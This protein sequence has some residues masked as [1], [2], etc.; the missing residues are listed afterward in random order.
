[1]KV[2][3]TGANGMLGRATVDYLSSVGDDVVGLTKDELDIA[4][5]ELVRNAVKTASPDTV[6]NC[7]AWTDVDGCETDREKNY[8]V[9]A[10]GPENLAVACR[11]IGANLITVST[12][13]VF[14]GRKDG[15]YTQRDE[16]NPESEYGWAKLTGERLAQA[17]LA[18][19]M[20]VRVGWLFGAGG[21]NFL[22]KL[23]EYLRD[24]QKLKIISDSYGTPTYAPHMARRLRELAVLDLPGIYHM[25]NSGEGT[26]YAGFARAIGGDNSLIEE[27][28]AETLLR[29]APRPQNSRLRCLLSEALKL[30]PLPDWEEALQHFLKS[31]ASSEAASQ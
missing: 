13:Y 7:A 10:R 27:V 29:P 3:V 5:T 19:T 2:L 30:E 14:D 12:D 17:A 25:A 1:M 15:F 31:T 9:H 28:K 22:S 8:G 21:K 20:V 23:P 18:R 26:S 16:P 24:A 6:M 11:E 4:D